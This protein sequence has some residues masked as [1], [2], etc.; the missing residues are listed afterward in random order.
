M[1]II[2]NDKQPKLY[3]RKKEKIILWK[4]CVRILCMQDQKKLLKNRFKERS[5]RKSRTMTKEFKNGKRFHIL[6]KM[7]YDQYP[8]LRH[9]HDYEVHLSRK[10]IVCRHNPVG[11]LVLLLWND[12]PI[13]PRRY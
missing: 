8:G 7:Q 6:I 11:F 3:T 1:E 4:K 10:S 13:M 5:Q 9:W 2:E 12:L